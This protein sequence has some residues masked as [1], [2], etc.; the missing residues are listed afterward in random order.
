MILLLWENIHK[1]LKKKSYFALGK[2][3]KKNTQLRRFST[4]G[5]VVSVPKLRSD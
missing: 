1:K 4:F 5:K 2:K 3:Q